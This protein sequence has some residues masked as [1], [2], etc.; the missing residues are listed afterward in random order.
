M[1]KL[2]LAVLATSHVIVMPNKLRGIYFM[3]ICISEIFGQLKFGECIHIY[4]IRNFPLYGIQ[5]H[6]TP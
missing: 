6:A 4:Q 3:K 1:K 5:L 2:L